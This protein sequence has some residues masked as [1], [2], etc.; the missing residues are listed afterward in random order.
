M[1]LTVNYRQ[2]APFV[3]RSWVL[4]PSVGLLFKF[5]SAFRVGGLASKGLGFKSLGGFL[6]VR[7]HAESFLAT[8]FNKAFDH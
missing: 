4:G 3:L 6:S 8:Y 7:T 2:E 5:G 1:G